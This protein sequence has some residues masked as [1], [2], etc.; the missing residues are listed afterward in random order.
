MRIRNK[1]ILTYTPIALVT[2]VVL[3]SLAYYGAK[4]ALTAQ[5]LNSLEGVAAKQERQIKGIIAQNEERL[6]LVS[7]RTQLRLS[8]EK[9]V[10]EPR[11]SYREKM[12]RILSDAG[13]SIGDFRRLSIQTLD[14]EVAAS[15]DPAMIGRVFAD[16]VFFVEGQLANRVDLFYRDT[17]GQLGVYLAGPLYLDDHLLG[18][19]VIDSDVSKL[20]ASTTDY[21]GLGKTGETLLVR[22]DGD[23][24]A[25]FLTPARFDAEAALVRTVSGQETDSPFIQA[26]LKK[27]R[28]FTG[29]SDYVNEAVIAVT[30]YIEPVDWGLVVQMRQSEA[31]APVVRLRTWLLTLIGVFSIG[32]ILASLQIARSISLPITRLTQVASRISGGALSE[33]A[34]IAGHGEVGTLAQAFNQMTEHLIR[35]INERRQAE[36]KFHALLKS[37]PDAIV[38]IET[39]G[40]ICLANLQAE[41]LF[42]YEDGEL[43]GKPI[44]MLLPTRYREGHVSLRQAF[45]DNPHFR[46]MAEDLDLYGLRKDGTQIPVEISLAPIETQGGFLVASAIRDISERK[47]TEA[48]L[49]QQANYDTLTGLPNRLLAADRLS[50]A[51]GRAR[52]IHKNVAVMFLDIDHFKNVNDT[53][54]HAVGDKLLTEVAGRLTECVREDDTVAR[55]GGDEFL[56]I[57]PELNALKDAEIVAEK[58][59]ETLNHPCSLGERELF[60]GASIGI[61]GFPVD[62]DDPDVLLRNA[63]AAMYRAKAAGRNTFR[64]FTPEM[65]V[66]LQRRLEIESHLRY[67]I[68]RD[69][70]YL[71]F[72]PQ[73]H[74]ESGKLVGAE[75]LLRWK[76]PELGAVTPDQFIPLAEETGL[77]NS[78]GEWV[79]VQACKIA[80]SWQTSTDAV[81]LAV[82]ISPVQFRGGRLIDT[83][84]RALEQSG[85]AAWLLEL[86]ITERVLVEDNPNTSEILKSLKE[87]GIR[88]VLDDFGKGYSS[89]SYLKRFPFD[90]LKIDRS[91]VSGVTINPEDAALCKAITAM[92][93]S[94]SLEV[95]AEGVETSAQWDFL[96]SHGVGLVQGFYISRPLAA[97]TLL[98]MMSA[99]NA[100]SHGVSGK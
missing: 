59:I 2:L 93:S 68:S 22:H 83:V 50:Q 90:V 55:L 67:A 16:A 60:V 98:D 36:E 92:A 44:E 58:V 48:R 86:E 18:V 43:L 97:D 31:Y 74:I 12:N 27:E 87:M 89:L 34:D 1:L 33:R 6:A 52:R 8:L 53:L 3:G 10:A 95:V 4:D 77:I 11:E 82:N 39:T 84:S 73:M 26:L 28:L 5:V 49:V 15:T 64:F 78:I 51:L 23:G 65:N 56:I 81:R 70:L 85:L 24:D 46:P 13:A 17:Q 54:G 66:Q 38:I 96:R 72:Q 47:H 75:A 40:V 62:S 45:C 32:V 88:L 9:Y 25:V 79:L 42:G 57:I 61:T 37:A 30:R 20:V 76:N 80:S 7:S 35:D 63:D 19:L 94:L 91:F 100:R 99:H 21:H 41:Q 69:E 29:A 14:G 71:H